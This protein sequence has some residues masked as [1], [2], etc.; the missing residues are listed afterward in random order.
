MYALALIASTFV[1]TFFWPASPEAAVALFVSQRGWNALLVGLVAAAGQGL[2]YVLIYPSGEQIRQR[3]PWF[4]RQ[5][6]RVR[7]RFGARL[8]QGGLPLACSSGLV[9]VPPSSV[10]VALAPGLGLRARWLLPVL[11]VMRVLR[12]TFIAAVASRVIR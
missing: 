2:A 1:G 9:G 4:G 11:F 8:A 6:E 7:L 10:L 12:F 5:C 3:W